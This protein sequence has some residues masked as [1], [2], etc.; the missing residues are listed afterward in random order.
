MNFLSGQHQKATALYREFPRPFWTLVVATFIDR[1][2]GALIFP[3]FA[4]YLTDRF[5]IGMAQVGLLF[6][7]WS[8]SSFPGSFLGGALA[9]RIGRKYLIIFSLLAS[10]L[11]T[12]AMGFVDS[13]EAFYVLALVSGIFTEV[14]GPAHNAIVADLLPEKQRAQGYGIIRVAFNISATLG[15]AIGGLLAA[16]SYL[17]L[18]VIDA[19]VSALVALYIFIAMP[20]T[21][22][23]PREDAP[24]ES[25][26]RTFAGYLVPLRDRIF[27]VFLIAGMLSWFVY[28]N[29]NTTLGVYLRDDHGISEYLY[30]L[31]LSMNA[32]MVVFL[33]FPITRRISPYPPMLVLAVG[34]AL[35]AVGFA[36]YGFT[37][38]YAL[39]LVAMVI[40]TIGEMLIAPVSQ[41]VV[42][43][44]SPE[45][46]R[47]RY[48]AVAGF[49]AGISFAF[50]PMVA[51]NIMDNYDS[52]LLWLMCG[53]VGAMSVLLYLYLNRATHLQPQ[54]VEI[55]AAG[56]DPPGGAEGSA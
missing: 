34:T 26:G 28:M 6:A 18:F 23:A 31:I 53:L 2:G 43:N 51:G 9:D 12:L 55:L 37:T 56:T 1:L 25:I 45:H 4:L 24:Q 42:A 44:L 35:Y 7:I 33:Q 27:I 11:S 3:F 5:G 48:M 16:R 13:I 22:P 49:S 8:L 21:K 39:F 14:G 41:S 46:M 19:L 10:S 20:E 50:G 15:P 30:G 36:M 47:G 29:M 40:I 38:T 52:R 17:L 54:P 32:I